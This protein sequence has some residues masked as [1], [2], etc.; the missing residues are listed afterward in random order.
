MATIA[1]VKRNVAQLNLL[2]E[3]LKAVAETKEDFV[4]A[5]VDQMRHGYNKEGRRIGEYKSAWYGDM[6]YRMNPLA[7]GYVDLTLSGSFTE[8]MFLTMV[9]K[10]FKISSTDNKTSGLTRKYG[11]SV[12]GLN[13]TYKPIAVN[14]NFRRVLFEKVHR[15]TKL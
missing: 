5:N 8:R 7:D 11:D 9:S 3:S 4:A 13:N 14:K 15:I 2:N 12:F 6:K 1:K 10:G